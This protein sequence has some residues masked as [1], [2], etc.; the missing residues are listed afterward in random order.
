M[1]KDLDLPY[2]EDMKLAKLDGW[3]LVDGRK[4]RVGGQ[5]TQT[6]E[7]NGRTRFGNGQAAGGNAGG[8]G[9]AAESGWD[10]C[11]GLPAAVTTGLRRG[12]L[13]KLE[14]GDLRLDAAQPVAL[15]RAA[16]T[17]DRK[18]AKVELS[19]QLVAELKKLHSPS[20]PTNA[21]VL[22]GRMPTTKQMREHLQAAGLSRVAD[23]V[24]H[25]FGDCG[26][27]PM[28]CA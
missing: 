1:L 5:S 28:R 8:N 26:G 17:K 7:E 11:R 15:V 20:L 3:D 18:P 23:D 14:W 10:F 21:R 24:E 4:R 19:R 22:A 6:G 2:Y 12:E 25:E 9:R 16:T 27:C 13:S